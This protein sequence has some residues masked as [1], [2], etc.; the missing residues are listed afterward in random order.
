MQIKRF[1]G[2]L[3]SCFFVYGFLVVGFLIS[4]FLGFKVSWFRGF[5]VS[6]FLGFL[7]SNNL[8]EFQSKL[9]YLLVIHDNTCRINGFMC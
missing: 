8:G 4:W 3:A 5:L 7:V 6:K 2:L 9:G 1:P